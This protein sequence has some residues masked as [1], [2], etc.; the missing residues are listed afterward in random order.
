[1]RRVA[2]I[3]DWLTGMRGGEAV[4]E[5]ILDLVPQAEIFTLFH[6]H[7]SVSARIESHAIHTSSL[8]R[9]ASNASDYRRL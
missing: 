4:L 1:M 9:R 5:G 2:V 3:H 6:F 7:G 8:Q